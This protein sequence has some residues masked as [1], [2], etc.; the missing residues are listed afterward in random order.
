LEDEPVAAKRRFRFTYASVT[1]IIALIISLS[2]GAYALSITGRDVVNDSL[3]GKDIREESLK[4]VPNAKKLGGIKGEGYVRRCGQGTVLAGGWVLGPG[5]SY[6]L[7]LYG[8]AFQEASGSFFGCKPLQ[9]VLIKR[10]GAGSYMVAFHPDRRNTL[11]AIG[12]IDNVYGNHDD[13]FISVGA[14]LNTEEGTAY[15]VE[16]RNAAGT[17]VDTPFNIYVY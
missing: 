10:T 7:S 15:S 11:F 13:A 12:N 2:G 17:A 16:I 1:A 14:G 4:A 6:N 9:E 5:N 8:P 3:S